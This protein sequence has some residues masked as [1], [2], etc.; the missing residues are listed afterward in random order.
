MEDNTDKLKKLYAS[1]GEKDLKEALEYIANFTLD[2]KLEQ[3]TQLIR[4]INSVTENHNLIFVIDVLGYLP[5]SKEQ[6]SYVEDKMN[7]ALHSF[8]ILKF[9]LPLDPET[10]KHLRNIWMYNFL[11]EYSTLPE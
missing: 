4:L 1:D 9:G 2:L 5:L 10:K 6:R 3:K 11:I 7:R 8:S